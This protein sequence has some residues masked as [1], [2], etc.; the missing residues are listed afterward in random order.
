MKGDTVWFPGNDNL[1]ACWQ[2][3][4]KWM[5]GENTVREIFAE[6]ELFLK[7]PQLWKNPRLWKWSHSSGRE[8]VTVYYVCTLCW[9]TTDRVREDK[10]LINLI[11]FG[12]GRLM[13]NLLRWEREDDDSCFVWKMRKSLMLFH[14]FFLFDPLWVGGV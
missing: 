14:F 6:Q 7:H 11:G 4:R 8:L 12:W 9:Y 10:S 13:N 3:E 1:H 2:P 5:K